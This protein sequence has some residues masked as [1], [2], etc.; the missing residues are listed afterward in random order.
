L[1]FVPPAAFA[2]SRGFVLTFYSECFLKEQSVPTA[3]IFNHISFRRGI[4]RLVCEANQPLSAIQY[5]G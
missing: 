3:S 4:K 5:Q 1:L 2:I